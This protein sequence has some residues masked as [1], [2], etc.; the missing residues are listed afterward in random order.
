MF[1]YSGSLLDGLGDLAPRAVVHVYFWLLRHSAEL[2]VKPQRTWWIAVAKWVDRLR[3][4]LLPIVRLESGLLR[5]L[6]D[7]R[8][9]ELVVV[10]KLLPSLN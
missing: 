4:L 6:C 5:L 9:R 7:L 8:I 3:H 10:L 2:L 1:N